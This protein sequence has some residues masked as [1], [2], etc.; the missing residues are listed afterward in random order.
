[1]GDRVGVTWRLIVAMVCGALV[2][3][4]CA[5]GQTPTTPRQ[6][7]AAP[8]GQAAAP[9][10]TT[11]R[12]LRMASIRE[13]VDGVV[14]FSG[15]G[16]ITKQYNW[17]FHAGLTVWDPKTGQLM[18]WLAQKVP[19]I[20][21]GDWKVNPDGTMDVTWKLKPNVKWHDGTAL[22][23][24]DF[25]FG[26]NVVRDPK[27]PLPRTGGVGFV[28]EVTAPDAQTLVMK[29]SEPF[30]GANE[31]TPAEFPAL[32]RHVLSG[33]YSQGNPQAFADS[34]FWT[35]EWMGLGPYKI[36]TW[37][38]GSH[39]E[40]VAFDDYVLGKPKI[41]KLDI[42]FI[43]DANAVVANLLSGDVEFTSVGTL[44]GDDLPPIKNAWES[45]NLGTVLSSITDVVGARLS[46]RDPSAPWVQDKRVR[47]ALVHGINRQDMADTFTPGTTPPN[48]WVAPDDPVYK[49]AEQRGF[50]KYP[51]DVSAADRL[52]REA[53]WTKGSDGIYQN[54]AGQ[55][56]NIEVRVVAN[57]PVNTRRGEALVDQ[58]KSSGF[59][60]QIY[61]IPSQA[62]DRQE[63]KA[64]A[65]GV[66]IMPDTMAY[67][68]FDL[69]NSKDIAAADNRWSARNLLAYVNPEFD[70]RLNEYNGTLELDKRLSQYADLQ[71][72]MADEMSYLPIYYDV[73]STT[74]AFRKGIRGPGPV[75]PSQMVGTW[76]IHTWEMD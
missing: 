32:P 63:Q 58:W 15:T 74:Q 50:P 27:V 65:P 25:V 14:V 7:G 29:W 43:V 76:N 53:G 35:R 64:R 20:A 33:L 30:F 46:Y 23:A 12:V 26:I 70:R 75:I 66:F 48:L 34:P 38:L 54:A 39:L 47:H 73:G 61:G 28:K 9:V 68:L 1:M 17:I 51:Y 62:S 69:F 67:D 42:R 44:R 71:R 10:R 11:P 24:E 36:G 49:L 37:E 2:I 3:T 5:G 6:D 16:D 13:P 4:G 21:D 18:P 31:G 59:G 72:W 45:Q 41:D 40:A 52:M 22:S 8:G 60:S 56:F 57:A 19:S 55:K